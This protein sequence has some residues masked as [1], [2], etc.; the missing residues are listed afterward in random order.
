[1]FEFKQINRKNVNNIKRNNFID[2]TIKP[3]DNKRKA[4]KIE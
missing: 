3:A 1:M 4:G 2:K